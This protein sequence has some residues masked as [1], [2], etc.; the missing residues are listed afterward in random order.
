MALAWRCPE[1]G[2]NPGNDGIDEVIT[3]PADSADA[4]A[5]GRDLPGPGGRVRG[6]GHDHGRYKI[7]DVGKAPG[8]T[9]MEEEMEELYVNA[10]ATHDG[11]EPCVDDLRGRGE[12]SVGVRAGRAMEPRS[13]RVRGA[14]TVQHVEGHTGGSVTASCRWTPRGQRTRAC[15]EPSGA[16][17][18]RSRVS[19]VRLIA[20]WAARGTS[21]T[22]SLG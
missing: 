9:G 16:R 18:G 5:Q 2:K 22:V 15:T 14:H 13:Q 4:P 3:L 7:V 19:P 8:S 6:R 1:C 11:P 20:G 12:A 17:S 10:L 21:V